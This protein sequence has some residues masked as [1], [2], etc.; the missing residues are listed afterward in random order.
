MIRQWHHRDDGPG[1]RTLFL[2]HAAVENPLPP[3]DDDD[4]RLLAPC[5]LKESTQPWSLQ[6]PPQTTARA[7][8]V[9]VRFPV[10]MFALAAEYRLPCEP[11]DAGAATIGWQRWRRQLLAQT[12]DRVI[13]V[14]EACYGILPLAE[15][16][17]L[18]G[19]KLKD[20]P[21]GI[22]T[23]RDVLAKYGLAGQG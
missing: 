18:G 8:R 14:A 11:G 13:I 12:R 17:R 19:V 6:H 21:P 20:V 1:G 16:S 7:V 10:R 22:G 5:S 4:R 3:F 23:R 2:T 9:H 15:C